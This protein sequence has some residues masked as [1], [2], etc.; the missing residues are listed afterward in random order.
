MWSAFSNLSFKTKG[1][2]LIAVPIAIELIFVSILTIYISKE[3]DRFRKV[4]ESKVLIRLIQRSHSAITRAFLIYSYSPRTQTIRAGEAEKIA[5]EIKQQDRWEQKVKLENVGPEL[6]SLAKEV[7]TMRGTALALTDDLKQAASEAKDDQRM[8]RLAFSYMPAIT[9]AKDIY[10]RLLEKESRMKQ[11]IP[12]REKKK[13]ELLTLITVGLFSGIGISA[14]LLYLFTRSFISRLN[15]TAARARAI[16]IGMPAGSLSQGSDEIAELDKAL[17]NAAVKLQELKERQSAIRDGAGDLILILSLDARLR[18]KTIGEVCQKH[19]GFSSEILIG[20]SILTLLNPELREETSKAFDSITRGGI[21]QAN[22]ET[23]IA[24]PDGSTGIFSWMV[25]WSKSKET[26]F[27]VVRDVSEGRRIEKLRQY[28]LSMAGHDLR[29][30]LT[31]ISMDLQMIL[32]GVRGPVPAPVASRVEEMDRELSRLIGY[33]NELLD[34]EKLEAHNAPL[35]TGAASASALCEAAIEN[36]GARLE[37]TADE[38]KMEKALEAMLASCARLA[39]GAAKLQIELEKQD[40][41]GVISL[42]IPGLNIAETERE[43]IFDKLRPASPTPDSGQTAGPGLGLAIARAVA[44]M[45]GGSATMSDGAT[46][47][48][49]IPLYKDDQDYLNSKENL[50]DSAMSTTEDRAP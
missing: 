29:S 26:F 38:T 2:I 14:T 22:L 19:W 8:Y 28:F 30:P 13:R 49:S 18:V 11:E 45:H 39:G 47:N 9:E 6:A 50:D 37:Q 10:R 3:A 31:A 16:A 42:T 12:D 17:Y 4:Q 35:S 36:L 23:R 48:L 34:L 15:Q 27:C 24:K 32:A 1:L 46:F 7:R 21:E 25:R 41:S 5:E 43:E 40:V 44:I 20:K 33:V